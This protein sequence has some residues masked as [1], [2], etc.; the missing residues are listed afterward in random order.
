MDLGSAMALLPGG[1]RL[2]NAARDIGGQLGSFSAHRMAK[3]ILGV[4]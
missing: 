4:A 2:A 1:V 3:G